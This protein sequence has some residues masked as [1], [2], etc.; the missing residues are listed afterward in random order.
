MEV[1]SPR[2]SWTRQ[3]NL[4]LKKLQTNCLQIFQ[5]QKNKQN[6]CCKKS[7]KSRNFT[8]IFFLQKIKKQT[9]YCNTLTQLENYNCNSHPIDKTKFHISTNFHKLKKLKINHGICHKPQILCKHKPIFLI[10]ETFCE[11][12]SGLHSYM[13]KFSTLSHVLTNS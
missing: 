11:I 2:S 1:Q 10:H 6:K 13:G 7:I 3:S 8:S 4:N 5:G 9:K 12:K